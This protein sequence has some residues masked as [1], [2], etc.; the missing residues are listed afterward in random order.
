[1]FKRIIQ[2]VAVCSL[3][4]IMMFAPI[5]QQPP[6]TKEEPIIKERIIVKPQEHKGIPARHIEIKTLT[7]SKTIGVSKE[8]IDLLALVTMA[9]AEG[10][11][12]RG[13]RLV[14]SAILNRVD[15]EY[16]PDTIKE[17]V[18]Q[19]SAFSCMWDGRI[20]KCYVQDEIRQLVVEELQ[21]R[22]DED[23]IFFRAGRYSDYGI[24]MFAEGGHYFSSYD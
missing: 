24:P 5:N 19:P 13:K 8:E 21:N 16:F 23:V 12:E 10:E 14:I 22:T 11:S 9:E 1:M 18:Y 7:K 3:S 6:I 15:S 2:S 17:V 4:I 20:E